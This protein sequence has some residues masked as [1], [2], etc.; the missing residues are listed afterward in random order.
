[1]KVVLTSDIKGVGNKG[2]L[3]EVSEGYYRNFLMPKALA[4][5]PND[6][7]ARQIAAGLA[8]KERQQQA[9][10]EKIKRVAASFEGK[11]ITLTAKA[12]GN[13]LF[14]AIHEAQIAEQLGI[15]KKLIKTEPIKT[16][17]EHTVVLRFPHE[18]EARIVVVVVV[19]DGTVSQV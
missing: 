18:F 4:V 1:M 6:P 13:K 3:K 11:R 19:G 12:K 7:Q 9:E 16:V 17:G 10:I 2:E 15:D 8:A 5:L 14:G